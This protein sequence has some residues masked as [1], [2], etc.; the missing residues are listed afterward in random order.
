MWFL[1]TSIHIGC[2]MGNY[3]VYYWGNTNWTRGSGPC[4][5]PKGGP[6]ENLILSGLKPK[7]KWRQSIERKKTMKKM[8]LFVYFCCV[9]LKLWPK[10]CQKWTFFAIF[11]WRQQK[12]YLQISIFIGSIW[13]ISLSTFRK[14]YGLWGYEQPFWRYCKRK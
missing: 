10:M 4:P 6:H 1:E 9:V 13:K 5:N 14:W 8:G 2:E 3:F 7:N 11:C 12:I